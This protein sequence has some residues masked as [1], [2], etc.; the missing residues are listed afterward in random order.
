MAVQ[1][2]LAVVT[3]GAHDA[4]QHCPTMEYTVWTPTRTDSTP[5]IFNCFTHSGLFRSLYDVVQRCPETRSVGVDAGRCLWTRDNYT[6]SEINRSTDKVPTGLNHRQQSGSTTDT[7][8][9]TTPNIDRTTNGRTL[10]TVSTRVPTPPWLAI[11]G[12]LL[13]SI[14]AKLAQNQGVT[15]PTSSTRANQ[16][17]S[18]IT[19]GWGSGCSTGGADGWRS[20]DVQMSVPVR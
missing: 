10:R 7:D 20:P 6:Q 12:P 5:Y 16:G 17:P 9:R 14:G 2:R 11:L 18:H 1:C 8:C 15:C 4:G 19:L 13:A 3:R